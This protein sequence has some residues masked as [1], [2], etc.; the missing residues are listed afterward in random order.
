MGRGE[1]CNTIIHPHD[2]PV[3]RVGVRILS[4]RFNGFLSHAPISTYNN[5]G[6]PHHE[7]VDQLQ[8]LDTTFHKEPRGPAAIALV[9]IKLRR[10]PYRPD[11]ELLFAPFLKCEEMHDI[12]FQIAICA[13]ML[14]YFTRVV[15][16]CL[17]SQS[18]KSFPCR[19]PHLCYSHG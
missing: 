14:A 10:C 18:I 15:L 2:R 1:E 4:N 13:K 9:P 19:I 5:L 6:G 16:V 11:G 7:N 8:D 12:N 17:Y 3:R